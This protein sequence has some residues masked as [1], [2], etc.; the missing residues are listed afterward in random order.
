MDAGFLG[1]SGR[2]TIRAWHARNLQVGT[3]DARSP[4]VSLLRSAYYH[5]A[6]LA[7][8]MGGIDRLLG[9]AE[10]TSFRT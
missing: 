8:Q 5:D 1:I 7:C 10:G 9:L 4:G 6:A 2:R 3:R